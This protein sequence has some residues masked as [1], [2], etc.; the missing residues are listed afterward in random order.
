MSRST[1]WDY[2]LWCVN[3]TNAWWV[4]PLAVLGDVCKSPFLL[5]WDVMYNAWTGILEPIGRGLKNV[6]NITIPPIVIEGVGKTL[7][8]IVPTAILAFGALC[9]YRLA[10]SGSIIDD[11][12]NLKPDISFNISSVI[13]KKLVGGLAA[14]VVVGAVL[15]RNADKARD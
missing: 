7:T 8:F 1:L 9:T 10:K 4:M 12:S 2:G 15:A 3:N 13:D 6:F 14:G 5:C 11:I